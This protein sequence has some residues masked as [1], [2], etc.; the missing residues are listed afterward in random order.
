MTT[1]PAK[2]H[3]TPLATFTPT[4]STRAWHS[5]P[6]PSQPLLATATAD[7]SVRVFSLA[8]FR[9]HSTVAGG[10]RRSVRCS[11][12]QPRGA[13]AGAGAATGGGRGAAGESVL[14]TASFDASVGIWRRWEPLEG[15]ARVGSSGAA[16]AAAAGH[17]GGSSGSGADEDDQDEEWRFAVVLDGH[18]SEVKGVSFSAGGQFVA[19]CS[20]DKH[21][22]V[23]EE[24]EEDNFETVAVLQEHEADVKC[25]AWH[26][27]EDLLA[28]GSYDDTV[29]LYREDVDDWVC[30]AVLAGHGATVWCVAFEP[31]V[32]SGWLDR[33]GLME[34]QSD[35]LV[36]RRESGPRLASCSDDLSIRIWRRVHKERSAVPVMPSIIRTNSVEEEWKEEAT[37][38]SAH[39]RSIYAVSWSAV[40][41]RIVSTGGDGRVIVFE[42]IWKSSTDQEPDAGLPWKSLTE[43]HILA[44]LDNGHG[45]YEINHVCWTKRRDKNRRRADEEIIIST[46]D[47]GEVKAWLLDT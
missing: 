29:R 33:E 39:E 5:A 12:W 14:A 21:V 23:W 46:G 4:G 30:C 41:G 10:H 36:K 1:K 25:V 38:P 26:P 32:A 15:V 37:L 22:W 8:T 19:T 2:M 44:V 35:F 42:E 34:E 17:D 40:T 11:A 47:D 7:R 6:H 13:G 43:W 24:L 16:G 28:S 27:A 18:E 3:I 9:L 20:R 45:V 31:E